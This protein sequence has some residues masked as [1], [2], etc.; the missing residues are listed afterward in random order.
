MST[1]AD[2]RRSGLHLPG[3]RDLAV[4]AAR[5]AAN[6]V[7]ENRPPGRVDVSAT[8]S[9]PTDVV[10]DFDTRSERL[11]RQH[12]LGARPD[13]GI[14]GEE[15]A[16]VDSRSGVVWVVDPIDGT[17]NFV[18]DHPCY[19]VSV[20]A[21]VDGESV[22]GAVVDIPTGATYA[23]VRGGGAT[24]QTDPAAAR[25]ELRVPEPPRLDQALVSTGFG[26]DSGLRES[27]A[28]AVAGLLGQ[29]RDIRRVGAA[30]LDLC[31]V[32]TGQVDAYF[33]Q[34]LN[35]W[36]RAA[37]GLVAAEAGARV[38]D[39]DG[40]RPSRRMTLATA[41]GLHDELVDAVR[42]CGF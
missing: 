16:S 15:G 9:S 3:L 34:G 42:G 26:Y 18:Y 7:A 23:A 31:M 11:L 12:L 20:A 28:R 10:T 4:R 33:E 24:L 32:A 30:S 5:E 6:W 2:D 21:Q 19:S 37:G 17:V 8:K 35:E 40:G 36:D 29:V 27:Q 13:D 14:L 39:L 25:R 41:P 1:A 38:V 22:A